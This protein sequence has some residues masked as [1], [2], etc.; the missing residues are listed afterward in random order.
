MRE[1]RVEDMIEVDYPME[2][3]E[4]I[5]IETNRSVGIDERDLI[6]LFRNEEELKKLEEEESKLFMQDV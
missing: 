2:L 5:D 4:S 1:Y 6:E 3:Q